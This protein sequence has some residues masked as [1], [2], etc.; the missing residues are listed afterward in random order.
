MISLTDEQFEQLRAVNAEVN[1]DSRFV[2]DPEIFRGSRYTAFPE[3][4]FPASK[5]HALEKIRRLVALGWPREEL[6]VTTCWTRPGDNTSYHAVLTL[7]TNLG[8]FILDALYARVMPVDR[9]S[10]DWHMRERPGV[11]WFPV[12]V[13]YR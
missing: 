12:T 11:G 10:Y 6:A 1:S 13:D 5:D 7:D 8:T 2:G 3:N 9:V 4:M